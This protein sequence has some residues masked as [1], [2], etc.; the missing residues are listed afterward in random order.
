MK[1][2]LVRWAIN[3][4]AIFVAVN[5]MPGI[6]FDRGPVALLLVAAIFGVVNTS[7]RPVL[8]FL[9]C[10]LV[11]VTLG[12]FTFVINAMLLLITAWFSRQFALGL[13]VDGFWSAFWAGLV[14]GLVSLLLSMMVGETRVKVVAGGGGLSTGC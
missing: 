4:L 7:L 14:I 5:V 12:L 3:T 1:S 9:T 10:P 8:T 11:I 2:L 13:R 6:H